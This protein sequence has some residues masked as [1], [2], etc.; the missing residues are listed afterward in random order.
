MSAEKRAVERAL[1]ILIRTD[2]R[3]KTIKHAIQYLEGRL[4]E[5]EAR[6][7]SWENF[8][9]ATVAWWTPVEFAAIPAR[10]PDFASGSGSMYWDLGD[11]VLRVSDHWGTSIRSCDWFLDGQEEVVAYCNY[12]AILRGHTYETASYAAICRYEDFAKQS[13][14]EAK[15][16]RQRQYGERVSQEAAA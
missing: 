9:D 15:A 7:V 5:I 11:A 16:M 4:A 3:R 14:P 6:P 2:R 13:A 10:K 1:S 12:S 8:H